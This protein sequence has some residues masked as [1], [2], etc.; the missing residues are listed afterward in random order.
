MD[1]ADLAH[2]FTFLKEQLRTPGNEYVQT[3]ARCLQVMLRLDEYR[4]AFV[5]VDGVTRCLQ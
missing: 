3:T 5:N 1:G 4:H 2:Y